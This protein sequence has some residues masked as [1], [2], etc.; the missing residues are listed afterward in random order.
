MKLLIS[1]GLQIQVKTD[2]LDPLKSGL[3]LPYFPLNPCLLAQC[4]PYPILLCPS[5]LSMSFL[6]LLLSRVSPSVQLILQKAPS[7]RVL[8]IF[9]GL[10][11]SFPSPGYLQ[12]DSR[13]HSHSHTLLSTA[14][15]L[16]PQA[17]GTLAREKGEGFVYLA[18]PFSLL[19]C[20]FRTNRFF[21]LYSQKMGQIQERFKT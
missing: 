5:F 9:K 12:H 14:Q 15:V 2:L 21:L 18:L 19:C 6:W 8:V 11:P 7:K 17:S 16:Y 3:C 4:R 1:T 10:L 20:P 13:P